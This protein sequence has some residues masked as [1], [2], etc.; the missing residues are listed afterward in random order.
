MNR[1]RHS[2]TN[3]DSP[4]SMRSFALR[5][6][7]Q[8]NHIS[9]QFRCV[10]PPANMENSTRIHCG[11]SNQTCIINTN[12]CILHMPNAIRFTH[13]HDLSPATS[14]VFNFVT[15]SNSYNRNYVPIWVYSIIILHEHRQR[16]T[17]THT[18]N[19]TAMHSSH[20]SK[21]RAESNNQG[22]NCIYVGAC[23]NAS[24]NVHN[25]NK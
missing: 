18:L 9:R 3:G 2:I 22:N 1:I 17:H 19:G 25:N 20:K 6:T 10:Q 15:H 16:I 7:K 13:F 12:F 24:R 5:A 21:W 4:S 8:W 14:S 23:S 11:F